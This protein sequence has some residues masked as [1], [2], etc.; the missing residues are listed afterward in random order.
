[1][2]GVVS[3]CG[4]STPQ[5]D[6]DKAKAYLAEGKTNAAI[7]EFKNAL[8]KDP[9]LAEAR[10]AL[11][12]T[13]LEYGE[14]DAALK[15]LSRAQDLGIPGDR[16][17]PPLLETKIDLGRR[18]EV[19]G[20]LESV[21]LN[22]RYHAIRGQALLASGERDRARADF[23]AAIKSD[24]A[25]PRAYLGL[26]QLSLAPPTPDITAALSALGSGVKAVPSSRR[27]W[28][29][30]GEVELNQQHAAEASAAFDKAAA[31][32]GNDFL[33]EM[34]L[35]RVRLLEN[36]PDDAKT[37]VDGVLQR[38]PK[39]PLALH[40]RGVIALSQKNLDDAENSLLAALA[41]IPNYPPSL[42][43]LSNVKYAQG[44][45]NQAVDYLRRYVAQDPDNPGP[46][47]ALAALLLETGDATGAIDALQSVSD[48]LTGRD[49]ALLGTAYLRAGQLNE[50]TRYL[51]AAD[52][53]LP[54][55]PEVKTQLALSLAAAGD[56]AGALAQLDAVIPASGEIASQTD[57]LRV[58]VNVRSGDLDAALVA[59]NQMVTRD[60]TKPLGFYLLG[61]VHAARK[62][63][64]A[65]RT[66]FEQ[67][68]KTDPKY[69][70][71]AI[72]LAR[73]DLVEGKA[74]DAR[75]HLEESI[76]A[77]PSDVGAL[78]ALA[79][80]ERSQGKNEEAQRLFE[81]ARAANT[82]ALAPRLELGRLA[83]Q[84]GDIALAQDVSV[85]A[86]RIEE[87]NPRV[88]LLRAMV[89]AQ[90]NDTANLAR[91]LDRL[92]VYLNQRPADAPSYWL[93]V[94]DLQRRVGRTELAR[95]TLERA[96]PDSAT[97]HN[98]LVALIQL[99]T[100][101]GSI[102][103][104]RSYLARLEK[105]GADPALCAELD[106][107]IALKSGKPDA[108]IELY[109][110]AA[111]RG[112][113]RGVAKLAETLAGQGEVDRAVNTLETWL[114]TN[115][116]DRDAARQLASIELGSG[117]SSEAIAGFERLLA[118]DAN[119]PVALN[120]LA[121]LYFEAKDPRAEATA[122]KAVA[123][124][125]DN[126]EIGD[127]LGW[128]LVHS[129]TPSATSEALTLLE[130]A[131]KARPDNPSVLYHLAVTQQKAGRRREAA[132]SVQRALAVG[133]FAE[134]EAAQQLS[135]RLNGG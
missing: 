5:E 20:E 129:D 35:A 3:A 73:L 118:K 57:A 86:E 19:L 98:A 127:T 66:A 38:A 46:R 40:L 26:A 82:A 27:L 124:A 84:R 51:S 120:N 24:P 30:L 97:E 37:I 91:Y 62:D 93:P 106:G 22:P 80:L 117:N 16:V 11:G 116:D 126:P 128:I 29:A 87:D 108:A 88:W 103:K 72:E 39:Y 33:P 112:S 41:V 14:P 75:R 56:S 15:E 8:Q 123:A 100:S 6:L 69:S 50:A 95:G 115:P 92:Q 114:K 79:D 12:E 21:T 132:Q 10:L 25:L 96:L 77:N 70:Q 71:A 78:T 85:E 125:P 99:E 32:P 74:A 130:S 101:G 17:T 104:A 45:L 113:A 65:A 107:D 122:R 68:L 135:E 42:L 31:L 90:A 76:A 111:Q 52:K 81:Q 105:A 43:A 18:Q 131:V 119:D 48:R 34:G 53:A 59:A 58:L 36:K 9:N 134:R 28:L 89:T 44:Q 94:G 102:D 63:S 67:A 83:L 133:P 121:W 2:L 64:A 110:K 13:Y 23:E 61:A 4:A 1:M 109:S 47:R 54:E 49:L 55:A 60:A 7:I